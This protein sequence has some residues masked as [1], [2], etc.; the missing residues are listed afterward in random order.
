MELDSDQLKQTELFSSLSTESIKTLINLGTH[1]V[2]D[3]DQTIV[4]EN[5][6]GKGIYY[7]IDGKVHI[8]KENPT[9][10]F[11][12]IYVTTLE[13]G[14]CFGEMSTFTEETSSA[15]VVSRT[16]TKLFFLPK[17]EINGFVNNQK[18]DGS[19]LLLNVIEKMSRNLRITTDSLTK[20][21]SLE[22]PTDDQEI[23]E[24]L[25]DLEY[26]DTV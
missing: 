23:I 25:D 24:L 22:D 14:D 7:I 18:N 19:R 2:V 26:V 16:R 10:K 9:Q 8:L 1:Q 17:N 3:S 20:L 5:D 12:E 11:P 4:S 21:K 13:K 15:S 6:K